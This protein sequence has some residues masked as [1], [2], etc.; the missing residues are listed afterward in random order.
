MKSF[1]TENIGLKILA[2]IGAVVLWL[3]VVNVDDPVISR[4]FTGIPV[5][6]LHGE[7]IEE[8]GKTYEILDD[9]DSIMVTISAKR[10]IIDQMSKDYIRATA[11][12][13][14]LTFMDTVPIE[15]RFTRF[16]DR[17]ENVNARKKNLQVKVENLARKQLEITVDVIGSVNAGKVL[18]NLQPSV[19][20]L[21][22]SGPESIVNTITQARAEIDVTGMSKDVS[23]T[24][25]VR[26]FDANGEEI[27][28]PMV[29]STVEE[30]HIDAQIMGTKEVN[31]L[32][33]ISGAPAD[34]FAATGGIDCDPKTVLV[35]GRGSVFDEM[36]HI[37]IP[38][39]KMSV[40][41]ARENVV[42]VVNISNYLP[43]GVFLAEEGFDGNVTATIHVEPLETRDVEIPVAAIT[44]ENIPEG[45]T[46]H[47][48]ETGSMKRIS[49]QGLSDVLNQ[50]DLTLISGTIDAATMVPRLAEDEVLEE[51]SVYEGSH[52]GQVNF[53][54]PAGVSIATPVYMEVVLNRE[55]EGAHA[56]Q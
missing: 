27:T 56:G 30:V 35:A 18:G 47:L 24:S 13:K 36:Q 32:A 16:S 43:E 29:V 20:V 41:G 33:A 19:N 6:V 21:S 53:T 38:E 28:D 11:D 39:G 55:S 8:Q 23:T 44:V 54:C 46:A 45:Y 22:V 48:A 10:S 9:S 15:V 50:L 3:I 34:G 37:V 17:I 25:V 4:P 7:V 42:S 26:L 51:G 52:D 49:V 5:E 40:A 12:M 14:E 31:I 2:L 1:L